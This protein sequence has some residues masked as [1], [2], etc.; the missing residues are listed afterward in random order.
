MTSICALQCVERG[1]L[2]LDADIS[3]VLTE[4]KDIQI[5]VSMD[6]ETG[7]VYKPATR[8]ITLRNLLTHSAGLGYEFAHP[9]LF[10]WKRWFIRQSAANRAKSRSTDLAVANQT[11]LLFEPDEGW[12]YG[13]G[14][15]WAGVAVS[16]VSGVSLQDYMQQNIW[17]PLGMTS[18]TF[19][20]NDRPDLLQRMATMSERGNDGKLSDGKNSRWKPGAIIT[21]ESGGG[22]CS[23]TANDFIKLLASVL[24]PNPKILRPETIDL[25]FSPSLVTPK[26]LSR[27]HA[28][29]QSAGTAATASNIPVGTK[30]DHGLGGILN[31]EK[32]GLT[33]R[34]EGSMQW[35]GLTNLFWWL[36]RKDGICGC[37]FGQLLPPGD[38]KS[39]EMYEAYEKAVNESFLDEGGVKGKL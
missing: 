11:P 1:L 3:D 22:G 24:D 31:M 36:D 9:K 32:I 5:L 15:D 8:K 37:Y 34:A 25:L 26:H 16:R 35:G 17:T 29:P 14:N 38:K 2:S 19:H 18:T 4:F 28:N 27:V 12:V 10:A 7:P 13:Y 23:S 6:D 33:G 39:V 30:V 21:N 20:V